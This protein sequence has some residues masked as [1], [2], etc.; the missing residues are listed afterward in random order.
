MDEARRIEMIFEPDAEKPAGFCGKSQNAVR[1]ADA[2]NRGRFAIDLNATPDKPQYCCRAL[3]AR[4]RN[5]AGC[6]G[7]GQKTAARKHQ[8]PAVVGPRLSP[9]RDRTASEGFGSAAA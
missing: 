9:L 4:G 3:R 8:A 7:R 2:K 5:G 1:L 6:D